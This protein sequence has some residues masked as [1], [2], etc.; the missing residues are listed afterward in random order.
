M[1]RD[2]SGRYS[3]GELELLQRWRTDSDIHLWLDIA[4]QPDDE[5]RALLESVGCDPLAVTDAFRQRH[6]PKIEAFDDNTF[7]LFRG[8]AS[9]DA[10]L[11]VSHQQLGIWVG[12]R[13][14]VTYHRDTSIS[15]THHW[16]SAPEAGLLTSPASLALQLV[17]YACGRYLDAL[18]EFDDR[19]GDL[20]D[21]L[22]SERSEEDMKELV[23]YRSRL[24][25][26]RRTFSYHKEMADLIMK[27]PGEMLPFL[28]DESD[29]SRRNVYDRCERLYSLCHMYYE[30]C[31]DLVEGHISLA[32]HNLN[33]TMK[34][35]TIIS[36]LFVPLTFIAGI[37]GM[38]FEYM[39]ELAWRHAYFVVIG[40][41]VLLTTAL[42]VVFRR[43]RWL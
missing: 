24:R 40:F 35:L 41:M 6:P 42:L 16:E 29:H 25:R 15:I 14:L 26:L 30:I 10:A 27:L 28:D 37:Y 20:E 36:A 33:Q 3:V 32:S 5:T 1:L 43:I 23:G 18:L 12:Q 8:I 31:G 19:L 4:A 39:P 11:D 22:V 34:V 9:I 7:L 2:A 38:N 17:H 21:G 13:L